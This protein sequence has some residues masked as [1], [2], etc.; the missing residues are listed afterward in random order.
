[1][2]ESDSSQG[3]VTVDL[4][5]SAQAS[6]QRL[7]QN[8]EQ[9]DEAIAA[10]TVST[11]DTSDGTSKSISMGSGTPKE[12]RDV[13]AGKFGLGRYLWPS[14]GTPHQEDINHLVD[15]T[16]GAS[17]A[18]VADSK[19][20]AETPVQDMQGEKEPASV[21]SKSDA[22][23]GSLRAL[24]KKILREFS[25]EL[26]S[27]GFF[28]SQDFDLTTCMQAKWEAL[29]EEVESARNATSARGHINRS[30]R[31]DIVDP[32]RGIADIR[33]DEPRI[34]E[35]LA[36]RADRRFWYN[37]WL[38]RDIMHAG[39]SHHL[40]SII[41]CLS[42]LLIGQLQAPEFATVLMQGYVQRRRISLQPAKYGD[43]V[44]SC[45][46]ASRDVEKP[47][48]LEMLI[49]SRRSVERPGLRYQRRGVNDAGGVANFVETEL[50]M[51]T[52]IENKDH[53]TSYVQT[54]GS[55]PL[56]WSQSPWSLKPI[57]IL[58]RG[59]EDNQKTLGK[60]FERQIKS[61]FGAVHI[62]NLAETSGKE[63]VL[64]AAYR[65]GVARL[66]RPEV[67]YNEWDFHHMCKGMRYERISL[68]LEQLM[69][70]ID[71]IAYVLSF[72]W[73]RN[74]N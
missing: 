35:P 27:G 3:D 9:L 10:N 46:P 67:I 17:S 60:H 12:G 32:P 38:S 63:G 50:I 61:Y 54:R 41:G 33:R 20:S 51:S 21:A 15:L 39:V 4:S 52:R 66:D 26:C 18:M 55:I 47:I 72:S 70:Q 58:E 13:H 69:P 65:D 68:L 62:V 64:V 57:P 11:A 24:D 30:A 2:S 53:L 34:S 29:A 74:G 36:S 56:Y 1:M 23:E 19:A 5:I 7:E 43:T 73:T 40:Q 22:E 49:I 71:H 31:Q 42:F 28:F 44:S 16:E 59:D 14:R 45:E 6:H 8:P 25:S 48:K 37:R